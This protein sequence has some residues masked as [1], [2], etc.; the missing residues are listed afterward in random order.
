MILFKGV[1][2]IFNQEDE[3]NQNRDLST[4]YPTPEK[5]GLRGDFYLWENLRGAMKKGTPTNNVEKF[6]AKL[7]KLFREKTGRSLFYKDIIYIDKY[8]HGGMSSG[9]ISTDWWRNEAIPLL[10]SR[11]TI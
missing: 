1:N 11:Y 3:K 8:A 2:I 5:W 9:M 4:F 7:I 6:E 10:I